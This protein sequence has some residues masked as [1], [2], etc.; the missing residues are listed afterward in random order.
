MTFI[1][2]NYIP[3]MTF[4]SVYKSKLN[5]PFLRITH[6]NKCSEHDTVIHR[7]SLF[8]QLLGHI[9]RMD[10]V[11]LISR[12]LTSF[13]VLLWFVNGVFFQLIDDPEE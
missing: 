4:I 11:K 6:T 9:L 12:I 10:L 3:F 8:L 13:Q 2:V 1:S 5:I 7:I